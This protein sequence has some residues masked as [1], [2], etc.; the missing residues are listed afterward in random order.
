[1][2]D[3]ARKLDDILRETMLKG[4]VEDEGWLRDTPWPLTEKDNP[5]GT[6]GY[7]LEVW[8]ESTGEQVIELT[9][10]E[11]EELKQH[12]AMI[13]LRNYFVKPWLERAEPVEPHA[14]AI[15]S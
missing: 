15:A 10:E 13:R 3:F 7:R 11:F 1:M 12:L 5:L 6:N 4:C 9:R 2:S 14:A 8:V